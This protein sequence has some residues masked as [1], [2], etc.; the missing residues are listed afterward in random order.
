MYSGLLTY[1]LGHLST[2]T[3]QVTGQVYWSRRTE[4]GLYFGL[5]D[6]GGPSSLPPLLGRLLWSGEGILSR[7]HPLP[8]PLPPPRPVR[9]L[10][11]PLRDTESKVSRPSKLHHRQTFDLRFRYTGGHSGVSFGLRTTATPPSVAALRVTL[12]KL[13]KEKSLRRPSG[14]PLLHREVLYSEPRPP[15][16]EP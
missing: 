12:D 2:Y 15:S 10:P 11:S 14:A 13:P 4:W 9:R 8:P 5:R 1:L 16:K 7:G 3:P 6:L